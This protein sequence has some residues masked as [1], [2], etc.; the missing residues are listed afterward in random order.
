MRS[1]RPTRAWSV[2][3][4]PLANNGG[5]VEDSRVRATS[6]AA[7]PRAH[8]S[9]HGSQATPSTPITAGLEQD[10][11]ADGIMIVLRW[12]QQKGRS[13][14]LQRCKTPSDQRLVSDLRTAALQVAPEL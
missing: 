14:A 7:A 3:E 2:A 10:E 11:T 13:A 6:F 1:P 5:G 4:P 12:C 8:K 9:T